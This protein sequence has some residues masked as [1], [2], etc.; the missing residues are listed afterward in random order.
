ME[1]WDN[2]FVGEL[3]ASATLAGLLFVAVSIN[4]SRIVQ[5]KN[6]PFRAME[7][8]LAFL[9]VLIV[10]S[11]AL[12]PKQQSGTFGLEVGLTG[13]T[14]W[15][16]QTW[17]LVKTFVEDKKY[18]QMLWRVLGNQIHPLPFMVSGALLFTGHPDGMYWLVPATL[19]AFMG[20]ILDSWVLLIEIQR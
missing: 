4:L 20:G 7:S 9:S 11:F 15:G 12:V 18:T 5:F 1:G 14:L 8:L 19:L 6:L 17:S 13:A 2:F 16:V 3:G 10:A